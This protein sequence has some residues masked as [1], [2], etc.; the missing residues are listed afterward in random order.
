M[1][2]FA[3]WVAALALY[4]FGGGGSVIQPPPSR[5]ALVQHATIGETETTPAVGV[6]RCGPAANPFD[7]QDLDAYVMVY[8]GWWVP[9][10]D[11]RCIEESVWL[12][13]TGN[14]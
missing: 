11:T 9:W 3:Q 14:G 1:L 2:T 6:W 10:L 7:P 13:G 8:T 12:E 4:L 5:P